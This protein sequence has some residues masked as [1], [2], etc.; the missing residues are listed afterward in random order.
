MLQLRPT[1]VSLPQPGGHNGN[2]GGSYD[3]VSART[4]DGRKLPILSLI[5]EYT[6]ECLALRMSRRLNSRDVMET[7]SDVMLGRGVPDEIP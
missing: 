5:D 6:R 4:H 7:L 1:G 3:F 2:S